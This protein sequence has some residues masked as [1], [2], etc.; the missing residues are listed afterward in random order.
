MSVIQ[1]FHKELDKINEENEQNTVEKPVKALSRRKQ[2][3]LDKLQLDL[4]LG[5]LE[6]DEKAK[7][8]KDIE[9]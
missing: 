3:R 7:A 8:E 1:K 6:G 9:W 2:K 5:R 4:E